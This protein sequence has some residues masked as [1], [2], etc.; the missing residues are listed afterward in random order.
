[1]GVGVD[2]LVWESP[3][4]LRAFGSSLSSDLAIRRSNN[5]LQFLGVAGRGGTLPL[6]I[7][8]QLRNR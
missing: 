6:P 5:V 4:M 7:L 2:R 8:F 1:M 3:S